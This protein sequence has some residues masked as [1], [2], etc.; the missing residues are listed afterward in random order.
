MRFVILLL[1][2]ITLTAPLAA[3]H[4][5]HPNPETGQATTKFPSKAEIEAAIDDMPD[6][7][8]IFDDMIALT[9][10]NDLSE[11]ME[12]S[13][14]RVKTDLETSGALEPDRN[15]LPDIKLTLKVLMG[16][17]SEEEVSEGLLETLTDIQA[18]MEKH[19]DDDSAADSAPRAPGP[20]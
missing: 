13:A 4:P 9:E 12:R 14:D 7:N 17:L 16:A 1:A 18:I 5:E 6:F 10:N 11:R 20:E 19:M 2:S 15:G 3:A 8:A